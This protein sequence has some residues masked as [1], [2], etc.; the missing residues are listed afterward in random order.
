MFVFHKENDFVHPIITSVCPICCLG[1]EKPGVQTAVAWNY[2]KQ[3]DNPKNSGLSY[4]YL[5]AKLPEIARNNTVW[6][7]KETHITPA[8]V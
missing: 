1:K 4:I 6:T 3:S 5:Y 8:G 7:G 2:T